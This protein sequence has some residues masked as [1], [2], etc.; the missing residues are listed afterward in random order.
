MP[1]IRRLGNSIGTWLL[2]SA[3]KV[4]IYD[5]QSGY[6]LHT[7]KLLQALDP[8]RA[9]FEFEVDV[10]AQAVVRNLP[11]AW[12]DIRTIYGVDKKSYFHPVRDSFLFLD[13]V[14]QVRKSYRNLQVGDDI[15][16]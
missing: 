5:N 16:T 1:F 9:G 14:W 8:Q 11:I 13:M 12:V 4:K 15:S 6:R 7:R 10:V 3:L 2:S